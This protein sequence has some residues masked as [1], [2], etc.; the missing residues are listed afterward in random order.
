[1][2]IPGY[3]SERFLQWFTSPLGFFLEYPT[4]GGAQPV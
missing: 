4:L 3:I 2:E 1:M